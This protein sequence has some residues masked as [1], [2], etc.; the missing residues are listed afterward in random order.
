[1]ITH[2]STK[3]SMEILDDDQT[4]Q[5]VLEI[6]ANSTGQDQPF[7]VFNVD[8]MLQKHARWMDK[9]ARVK[10]YYAVQCNDNE[11]VLQTLLTLGV[12]F[13]CASEGEVRR[14]LS[15]GVEP[16]RIIFDQPFKM[17]SHLRFAARKNVRKLTFDSDTELYKIQKQFP[18]ARFVIHV[19][20]SIT[21]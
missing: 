1:M 16:D 9:L 13:S 19:V 15:L 20:L 3:Q 17:L 2:I 10:P 11:N 4:L 14:I 5:S 6:I 7:F 18:A 12:G 8:D 21:S